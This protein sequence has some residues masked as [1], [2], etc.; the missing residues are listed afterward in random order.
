MSSLARQDVV[1]VDGV[2][3]G[4]RP[5]VPLIDGRPTCGSR[6]GRFTRG[7]LFVQGKI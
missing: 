1:E 2:D 5:G 4:N 7:N 3:A 6:P